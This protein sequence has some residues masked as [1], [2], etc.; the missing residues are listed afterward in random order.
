VRSDF[1]SNLGHIAYLLA[2]LW[3]FRF[4]AETID[5]PKDGL[6][7]LRLERYIS[8]RNR[9]AMRFPVVLRQAPDQ[10]FR[11]LATHAHEVR[12]VGL[13]SQVLQEAT[14]RRAGMQ[15]LDL[16]PMS[17]ALPNCCSALCCVVFVIITSSSS[18]LCSSAQR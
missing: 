15:L 17:P 6:E 14:D 11:F 5:A 3:K 16:V 10:G 1:T 2:M 13:L 12:L 8:L 7:P 18:L 4:G 9:W